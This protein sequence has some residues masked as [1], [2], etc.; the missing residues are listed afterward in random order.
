[1]M[2][3]FVS[4]SQSFK[5]ITITGLK[6]IK[7]KSDKPCTL[8]KSFGF[9]GSKVWVKDGCVATFQISFTA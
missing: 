3:T 5:G 9:K 7:R 4:G 8:G 2:K 1:M 6:L